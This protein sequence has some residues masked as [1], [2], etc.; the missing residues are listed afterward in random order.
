M[1][2]V[3]LVAALCGP[4]MAQAPQ[5]L[6]RV[7]VDGIPVAKSPLDPMS[8]MALPGTGSCGAFK[9]TDRA[10]NFPFPTA[11]PNTE[12]PNAVND[13][14]DGKKLVGSAGP[15]VDQT[16]AKPLDL[17]NQY[18]VSGRQANGDFVLTPECLP[19]QFGCD[20]PGSSGM[21][22]TIFGTR[23]R[24]FFNVQTNWVGQ[25]MKF[26]VVADNAVA[27]YFYALPKPGDPTPTKAKEYLLISHGVDSNR[28]RITNEIVFPEAGLYPIEIVHATSGESAILEVAVLFNK[29]EVPDY[30]DIEQNSRPLNQ[31]PNVFSLEYTKPANF[32]QTANGL[33]SYPAGT[34][35]Q[36]NREYAKPSAMPLPTNGSQC[37]SGFFC[38]AAALCEYCPYATDDKLCTPNC[39]HCQNPAPICWRKD[40]NA[41]ENSEC[42]E[43]LVETDC[44]DGASCVNHKCVP[45]RPPAVLC[46]GS[47]S[48]GVDANLQP[49]DDCRSYAAV[50]PCTKDADCPAGQACDVANTSC[51]DQLSECRFDD[52]CGRDCIDCKNATGT[53]RPRPHCLDGKVCVECR[54]DTDCP[55][56]NYCRSGDCV[57]CTEDRHCG[58]SCVSC[59][60]RV[61]PAPACEITSTGTPFCLVTGGQADT[62]KCV[63]CLADSDCGAGNQCNLN[64]HLCIV[65]DPNSQPPCPTGLFRKG[66]EC[67]APNGCVEV[68]KDNRDCQ[69]NQCCTQGT[70]GVRKCQTGRCAGTAG[71]ALCGCSVADVSNPI[72]DNNTIHPNGAESARSRGALL[73]LVSM[74]LCVLMLRRRQLPWA[75]RQGGAR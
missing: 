5:Q 40:P 52:K 63:A 62:A 15:R 34:C 22:T 75:A 37:D 2:A 30:D 41:P 32:F 48:F 59:A 18:D 7:T 33:L 56:G 27:I 28:L 3:G 55:D 26:G 1:F 69:G 43:C 25:P 10:A 12:F 74:L 54:I 67:I 50:S 45:R 64:T 42:V 13:F 61:G 73:G 8:G 11:T 71:G 6:G 21:I 44:K 47:V 65:N 51:V 68:C 14:M 70:D 57:P 31:A 39:I 35:R 66:E 53:G 20:F 16:L 58:A 36:C 23:F 29:S 4:V 17:S 60:Y 49:T 46:A 19:S 9:S 24:G 38:N 72:V